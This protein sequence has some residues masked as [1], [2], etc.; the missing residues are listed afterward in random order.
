MVR[1]QVSRVG[2]DAVG[3]CG[4]APSDS[5][6]TELEIVVNWRMVALGAAL[7]VL[8]VVWPVLGFLCFAGPMA[9][10][11][12]LPAV[13]ESPR[14]PAAAPRSQSPRFRFDPAT[15]HLN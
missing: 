12:A 10:P 4:R 1:A 3:G 9:E 15:T 8:L 7:A 6:K 14:A 11:T 2:Y 5:S 13:D